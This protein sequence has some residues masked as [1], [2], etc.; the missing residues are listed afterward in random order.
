M[1]RV[2]RVQK[3]SASRKKNQPSGRINT[4]NAI[5]VTRRCACTAA[6]VL[7]YAVCVC[8]CVLEFSRIVPGETPRP[9]KAPGDRSLLLQEPCPG[10]GRGSRVAIG[11]VEAYPIERI[12]YVSI[13]SPSTCTAVRRCA[14]TI[15]PHKGMRKIIIHTASPPFQVCPHQDRTKRQAERLG[16]YGGQL[17]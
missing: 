6:E 16:I 11:P 5:Q 10:R 7:L 9:Q 13:R 14:P 4:Q 17:W 15:V 8:V 12:N 3:A 2:G 1:Q